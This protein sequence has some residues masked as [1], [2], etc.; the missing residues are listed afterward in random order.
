[1]LQLDEELN[2]ETI[3]GGSVDIYRYSFLRYFLLKYPQLHIFTY[4]STG[5][6]A[7]W[8]QGKWHNHFIS[9]NERKKS[10]LICCN[11][12]HQKFLNR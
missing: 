1:M 4:T 3:F 6:E 2:Q 10:K 5:E 7:K 12:I 9:Q 11:N 8:G